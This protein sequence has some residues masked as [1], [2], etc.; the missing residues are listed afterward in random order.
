[1]TMQNLQEILNKIAQEVG[2]LREQGEVAQYIPELAKVEPDQ[3][4]M[5]VYFL[6]GS[7]VCV[8]DADV[9][10]S[11]QSITKLFALALAY[12]KEKENLWNRVGKEASGSPFD[13]LWQLEYEH[14][15]PRNPFINA[16]ALVITDILLSHTQPADEA[17]LD[18]MRLITDE[19][20]LDFDHPIAD[21]EYRHADRNHAIAYLMKDFGNIHQPIEALMRSYSRQCSVK[22]TC[23]E[24]AKA[25]SFLAQHGTIPWSGQQLLSRSEAKRI[26]SLMVTCGT[27]D[28]AGE[29][30]YRIGLPTKS[31]VGGGILAVIPDKL[32][33]AVWSPRLDESGNSPAG[34]YALERFTSLTT[35]SIF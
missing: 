26:N 10:F 24:L 6:D 33:V 19:P 35:R 11:L 9:R 23:L 18:F 13:S 31:G 27:Y 25:G 5:A 4:G 12:S 14:G 7:M 16:G 17:V 34:V 15:I 3:F 1:M 8:G 32:S 22:M 28:C 2:L 30:A 29:F 20:L 21:S